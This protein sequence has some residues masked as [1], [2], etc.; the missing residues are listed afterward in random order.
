LY[1]S[2]A[3]RVALE[4]VILGA[5]CTRLN[6]LG[7]ALLLLIH[8]LFVKLLVNLGALGVGLGL[9]LLDRYLV[10]LPV[11]GFEVSGVRQLLLRLPLSDESRPD[12]GKG[13]LLCELAGGGLGLERAFNLL[14]LDVTLPFS[15]LAE[16]GLTDIGRHGEPLA[17]LDVAGLYLAHVG[18][19]DAGVAP[20]IGKV[21]YIM[22]LL[23]SRARAEDASNQSVAVCAKPYAGLGG[24]PATRVNE[25]NSRVLELQEEH[26]GHSLELKGPSRGVSAALATVAVCQGLFSLIVLKC[27]LHGG[28]AMHG[29]AQAQYV[30]AISGLGD[31]AAATRTSTHADDFPGTHSFC[32]RV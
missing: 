1:N 27:A 30:A 28:G 7:L 6:P 16:V 10:L 15:D 19:R 31:G 11:G 4:Q 24:Q 18:V 29:H 23:G 8:D 17:V 2:G 22:S 13:L 21:G 26:L 12:P 14:L 25:I 5:Y 32:A 20:V 3:G 9:A